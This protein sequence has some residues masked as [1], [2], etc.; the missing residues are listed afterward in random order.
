M[1]MHR[2][3]HAFDRHTKLLAGFYRYL[4]IMDGHNSYVNM[5]FINYCDQNRILFIILPSHITHRLQPVNVG[6]FGFLAEYYSQE[7][8]RFVANI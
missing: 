6:L 2:L 5:R 7:I 3:Q 1:G 8:D 4:F